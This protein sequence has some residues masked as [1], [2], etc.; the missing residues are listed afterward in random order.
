[1]TTDI[2]KALAIFQEEEQITESDYFILNDDSIS[3]VKVYVGDHDKLFEQWEKLSSDPEETAYDYIF[4]EW[5]DRECTNVEIH[6]LDAY[7]E[8]DYDQKY[9]VYTDSEADDEW[10]LKL[11]QYVDD[12]ILQELPKQY[13]PYF[14]SEAWKQDA[15][16][17]GRGTTLSSY[18]NQ[19][20]EQ[21]VNG[22]TYYLY[23]QN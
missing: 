5:L 19:E 14:D 20:I 7:D 17:N 2:E 4:E 10:E 9:K 21:T 22:T 3:D 11:E 16:Y 23:R 13:R 12:C 8:N 15:K 18:D 1:M 6:E